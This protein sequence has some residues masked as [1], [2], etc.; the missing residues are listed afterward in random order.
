MSKYIRPKIT[1]GRVFFT[2]CLAERGSDLLLREVESLR[3][4]VR[5]TRK[6]RPFEINAFVVLPDHLHAVWTLPAGDRDFSTRWGVI[7]ARFGLS[8][9][10]G[11]RRASHVARRERGIW[12][13]RFWE[14]HI[15]DDASYRACV[16]YCWY[17]LVKHGFVKS[18]LEWQFSSV[19]RDQR[20]GVCS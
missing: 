1:G 7:K 17:N 3:E 14:H 16:E 12:Q 11:T 19:H 18:P 5:L 4:A 8:V 13:R 2:V 20:S 6:G 15:R 9:P 10:A